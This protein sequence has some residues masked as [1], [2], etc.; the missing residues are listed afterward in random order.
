MIINVQHPAVVEGEP[1]YGNPH[2]A[3][4]KTQKLGL[5]S[6]VN[7]PNGDE[8]GYTYKVKRGNKVGKFNNTE[9]CGTSGKI[10]TISPKLK[11]KITY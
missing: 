1:A 9:L 3:E 7:N 11:K 6:S 2:E 10:A 5:M 8:F 4:W